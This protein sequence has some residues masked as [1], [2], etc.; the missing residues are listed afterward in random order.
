MIARRCGWYDLLYVRT[1]LIDKRL[2]RGRAI[3]RGLLS[4][5]VRLN[6]RVDVGI[7]PFFFFLFLFSSHM[8]GTYT[9]HIWVCSLRLY[10]V[11]FAHAA[12][13]CWR[14]VS[15]FM[16][17]A[18]NLLYKYKYIHVNV[19]LFARVRWG[20]R[21]GMGCVMVDLVKFMV[22]SKK[23]FRN[24]MQSRQLIAAVLFSSQHIDESIPFRRKGE[25]K[26]KHWPPT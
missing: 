2:Q 7:R 19:H 24:S 10:P 14:I 17:G 1:Y 4:N 8:C 16:S 5:W 3:G 26:A 9:V 25:W 23:W 22:S 20:I 12:F 15:V 6:S 18:K 13:R 21:E 11:Y